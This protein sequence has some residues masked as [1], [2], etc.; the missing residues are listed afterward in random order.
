MVWIALSIDGCARAAF[1]IV[2]F[3][4]AKFWGMLNVDKEHMSP[5]IYSPLSEKIRLPI[6]YSRIT[7]EHTIHMVNAVKNNPACLH[8]RRSPYRLIYPSP[9]K[10]KNV[11]VR[12][13]FAGYLTSSRNLD[14]NL[15]IA[16]RYWTGF[17]VYALLPYVLRLDNVFASTTML[18]V[19]NSVRSGVLQTCMVF[20]DSCY[21]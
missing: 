9:I 14:M 11:I 20:Y 13:F 16:A 1:R 6:H 18:Y 15:L 17:I 21:V 10:K 5:Q 8:W 19:R 12:Y 2:L 7:S 3:S 4:T